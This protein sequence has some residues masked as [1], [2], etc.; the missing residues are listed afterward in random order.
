[1]KISNRAKKLDNRV[2]SNNY[3]MTILGK[4]NAGLYL[5]L[6]DNK[7][8]KSITMFISIKE[9]DQIVEYMKGD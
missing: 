5:L 1:M 9:L 2:K 4:G 8:Y 3:E 6:D 7:E